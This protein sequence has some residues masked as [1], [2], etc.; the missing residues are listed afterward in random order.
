MTRSLAV[1]TA[2][3]RGHQI[4]LTLALGSQHQLETHVASSTGCLHTLRHPSLNGI[5]EAFHPT[6]ATISGVAIDISGSELKILCAEILGRWLGY[7]EDDFHLW[8]CLGHSPS[9]RVVPAETSLFFFRGGI[10]LADEPKMLLSTRL[11]PLDSITRGLSLPG[12]RI[13][14]APTSS[15]S[16]EGSSYRECRT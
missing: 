5:R 15:V 4:S 16:G 10:R 2:R 14:N 11:D 8:L 12:W 6:P 1:T 9:S 13:P 3:N 7:Q